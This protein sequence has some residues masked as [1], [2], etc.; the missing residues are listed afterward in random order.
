MQLFV[1]EQP[2]SAIA[3]DFYINCGGK[4]TM[5]RGYSSGASATAGGY[6]LKV[7]GQGDT[8]STVFDLDGGGAN[9]ATDV[10]KL[11]EYGFELGGNTQHIRKNA[12]VIIIE[13]YMEGE[14]ADHRV[15]SASLNDEN[16]ATGTGP[17]L[18]PKESYDYS[19][20]DEDHL[21]WIRKEA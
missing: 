7:A 6:W 1:L 5:V 20:G 14:T 13:A 15:R 18:N 4:P 19:E 3:K 2:A 21:N 12:T 16:I 11:T 9:T 17:W 8:N 10:C